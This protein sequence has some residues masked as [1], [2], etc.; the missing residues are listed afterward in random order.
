MCLPE[1]LIHFFLSILGGQDAL[2]LFR[3]AHEF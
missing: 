2:T 3:I 1:F